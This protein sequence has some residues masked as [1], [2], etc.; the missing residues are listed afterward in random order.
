MGRYLIQS[1]DIERDIFRDIFDQ[2]RHNPY[3]FTPDVLSLLERYAPS[4]WHVE[5]FDWLL[6]RPTTNIKTGDTDFGMYAIVFSN[7]SEAVG[8]FLANYKPSEVL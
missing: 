3:H 6:E 2:S 5:R 1:Y 7:P 4:G 8:F